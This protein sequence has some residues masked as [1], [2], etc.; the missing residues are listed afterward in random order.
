MTKK[1]IAFLFTGLM[2]GNN[3][4]NIEQQQE[5]KHMQN[6]K[7]FIFN[8][9]FLKNYNYDI[10]IST[11]KIIKKNV[12]ELFGEENIKNIHTFDND[13][14]E[15][16]LVPIHKN[17]PPID[18]FIKNNNHN[19]SCM[20]SIIQ[21]YKILDAWNLLENYQSYK[22]YDYIIRIR[23][24]NLVI[25]DINPIIEYFETKKTLQLLGEWDLFSIGTP[26]IMR[27]LCSDL[28]YKLG[29]YD[30]TINNHHFQSNIITRH[31]Y[32]LRL[33]SKETWYFTN[34]IQYFEHLFYYCET[35]GL[36]IDETIQKKHFVLLCCPYNKN[37]C[38]V[39]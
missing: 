35:L 5:S 7:K 22:N 25:E 19:N 4:G 21:Q 14:D 34:E 1:N 39:E 28:I 17:I 2:R 18:Y 38:C 30:F 16:F 10:F 23:L 37:T 9:L 26:D 15:K 29:T 20:R 27:H 12:F 32:Q 33:S 3:L 31:G 11:D 24:D 13:E 36:S 8:E 6:Y